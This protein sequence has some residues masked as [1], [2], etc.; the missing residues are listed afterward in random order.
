[1]AQ[2]IRGTTPTL[3]F[4]FS[5]VTVGNITKAILTAK[6]DST[7]MIEKDLEAA[8]IGEKSISWTLAQED[9]LKLKSGR[10]AEIVCDWKTDSGVRGRSNQ[11]KVDIGEP[12][13]N[14]VI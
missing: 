13:K 12:G 5:D 11:L 3:E 6:Q 9:T 8:T 2:I 4:K 10:A 14:E 7:I 1:M